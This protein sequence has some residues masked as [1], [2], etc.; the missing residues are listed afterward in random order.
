MEGAGLGRERG[1]KVQEIHGGVARRMFRGG[2]PKLHPAE[3]TRSLGTPNFSPH[4]A[5]TLDGG[6]EFF[7]ETAK[8][9]AS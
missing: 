3:Q 8:A 9:F 5:S 1:E 6:P 7:I 2:R 4:R